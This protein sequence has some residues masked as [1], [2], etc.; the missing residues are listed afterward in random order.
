M[1]VPVRCLSIHA[2]YR[3]HHSGA[4]CSG[5][6]AIPADAHVIRIAA[7]LG[8][9]SPQPLFE[10]RP[11]AGETDFLAAVPGGAC[12]FFEADNGRLCTIHRVAGAAALPSACRHFPRVFLHDA[13]GMFVSLSH[14]CPT[15]AGLLMGDGP[16]TI[17]E[18][19]GPVA[20]EDGIEAFEAVDALP[21]LL[22]PGLLM[23][24]EAYDVW[25]R[26]SIATFARSDLTHQQALAVISAAT[27][28]VRLWKAGDRS[29]VARV[30]ESFAAVDPASFAHD[31]RR[32]AFDRPVKRYLA[33]KLFGHRFAYEARGLRSMV[34]WLRVCLARFRHEAARLASGGSEVVDRN[35]FIEAIRAADLALVHRVDTLALARSLEPLE[36]QP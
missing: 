15:A 27:E 7:A 5:V 34:E 2:R 25:E 31:D 14:F 23:D 36:Q 16:L 24:L 8:P 10:R 28:A 26:M 29:L 9:H 32:H 3:C 35:L 11:D 13:R 21:P 17:V 4:C 6:F 1:G 30:E 18:A 12:V 19:D 20:L 22:R 33:A